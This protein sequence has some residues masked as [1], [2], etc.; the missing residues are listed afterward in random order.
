VDSTLR[1]TAELRYDASSTA[2]SGRS[3]SI[4]GSLPDKASGGYIVAYV[5]DTDVRGDD[6][7][8]CDGGSSSTGRSHDRERRENRRERVQ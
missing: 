2:T 6:W 7:A 5:M 3:R 8:Q 1:V 4:S